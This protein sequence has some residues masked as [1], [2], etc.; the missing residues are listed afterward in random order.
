MPTAFDY[1]IIGAGS[2][3]CVLANRLSEQ[4]G[5]RVLLLEAG[6]SHRGSVM[7]ALPIG[8]G[9]TYYDPKVNWCLNTKADPN[10][11]HREHYWPRGKVLGGSSAI[12]AMVIT[13]G[14]SR[15]FMDWRQKLGAGWS[16]ESL[17]KGF[18]TMAQQFNF[19]TYPE[20]MHPM[21]QSFFAACAH[22]D[23]AWTDN[24]N[25]VEESAVG[26]YPLAIRR[27]RRV[28]A[29]TAYLD[30]V[31]MRRNLTILTG[32]QAEKICFDDQNR[33]IAVETRHRKRGLERFTATGE[34]LLCGGSIHSPLLLEQSG[35]GAADRLRDC[36][37]PSRI[38][39]A[40]VGAHLQDH[41]GASHYYG[42]DQATLND[43]LGTWTG[44]LKAAMQYAFFRNG[45]FSL[46]L[47]HAGGYARLHPGSQNPD[48]QL[49][50]S[51][52]QFSHA[53]KDTRPKVAVSGNSGFLLGFNIARPTS[54]GSVHSTPQGEPEVHPNYLDTAY[55]Q[56]MA[57]LGSRF[58]QTL[59]RHSAFEGVITDR[60]I[61]DTILETDEEL[62]QDF[63][64]RSGTIY[65]PCGTVR[66]AQK[67][68]DGVVDPAFRVFGT[69]GLRVIDAS[70]FPSIPSANLSAVVMMVAEK[71]SDVIVGI[72]AE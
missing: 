21:C 52:M 3:G 62:L 32:T 11:G 30:P 57:I 48:T 12:N 14:L 24:L 13:R 67:A 63:R 8:Y 53:P 16:A 18:Q 34:I 19:C 61:P 59:S 54:E 23:I 22:H 28:S 1:I 43:A 55:D 44:K 38:D 25:A 26:Y 17:L 5:K 65:H 46:S 37:I 40:H 29:A 41:L 4:A 20:A 27:G 49:Y 56:E 70:V 72:S 31:R 47:N 10:T 64:Q 15:D 9:K 39:N 58:L 51:P 45:P 2:A 35:I 68:A 33:A 66:M 50:F 71:A 36:G 69:Q 6:G 60:L 42:T 7:L